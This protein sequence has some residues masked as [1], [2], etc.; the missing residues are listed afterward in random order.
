M[1]KIGLCPG[2]QIYQQIWTSPEVT[3]ED[4]VTGLGHPE[5]RVLCPSLVSLAEGYL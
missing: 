4:M 2:N 1:Q 3:W 5:P